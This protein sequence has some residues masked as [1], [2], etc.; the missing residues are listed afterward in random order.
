M[1]FD[2]AEEL[3]ILRVWGLELRTL[4][5]PGDVALSRVTIVQLEL[6]D[7]AACGIRHQILLV[8]LKSGVLEPP[9]NS[10]I[11]GG[12]RR[13]S[14]PTSGSRWNAW[15]C[16]REEVELSM[17]LISYCGRQSRIRMGSGRRGVSG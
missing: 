2:L 11:P 12:W 14:I 17:W 3:T 15:N 4:W 10:C 8:Q 6:L 7:A 1:R 13:E 9:C 16:T 5:G